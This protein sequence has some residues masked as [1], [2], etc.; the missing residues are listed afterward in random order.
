MKER[1]LYELRTQ[2]Y[3]RIRAAHLSQRTLSP[4]TL[5]RLFP[6]P[7]TPPEDLSD[8]ALMQDTTSSSSSSHYPPTPSSP[9]LQFDSKILDQLDAIMEEQQRVLQSL[10]V[11][12]FFVTKEP[13]MV[14]R[15]RVVVEVMRGVSMDSSLPLHP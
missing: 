1:E 15:Q 5:N 2:L 4:M 9:L 3:D 12:G 7:L 11:P 13:K 10:G 14:E 8:L 6:S